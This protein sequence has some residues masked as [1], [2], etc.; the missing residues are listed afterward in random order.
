M[1]KGCVQLTDDVMGPQH[2]CVNDFRGKT[3]NEGGMSSASCTVYMY[4]YVLPSMQYFKFPLFCNDH[5]LNFLLTSY[6]RGTS[7]ACDPLYSIFMISDEVSNKNSICRLFVLYGERHT[8]ETGRGKL[9][10]CLSV[11]QKVL[12]DTALEN[13][14]M[15]LD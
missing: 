4:L 8:Q 1:A 2:M 14:C 6:I 12:D 15:H 11:N 5:E 7:G 13:L 10:F 9:L 3:N